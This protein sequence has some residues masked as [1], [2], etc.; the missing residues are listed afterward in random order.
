MQPGDGI[1][2]PVTHPHWVKVGNDVSVSFSIT[3]QTRQNER[4]SALYALHNQQ[5]ARGRQPRPVGQS[6]WRDSLEYNW[7]R[8]CRRL[9]SILGKTTQPEESA[10]GMRM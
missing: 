5:R 9:A 1:H 6:A 4:R 7:H 10:A 3:F 2:V 8:V